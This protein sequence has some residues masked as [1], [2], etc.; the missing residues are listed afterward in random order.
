MGRIPRVVAPGLPHY[1]TQRGNRRQGT[2]PFEDDCD[3]RT[4]LIA[5]WCDTSGVGVV[6]LIVLPESRPT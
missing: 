4:N 2:F 3:A 5:E 1:L 6:V